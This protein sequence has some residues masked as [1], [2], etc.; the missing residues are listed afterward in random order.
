M[1]GV[2]HRLERYWYI[3]TSEGAVVE[4]TEEM[5]ES[6]DEER[7]Q[8]GNYFETKEEAE[9][10]VEK[11]KAW[12]R[13]QDAGVTFHAKVIDYKWYLMPKINDKSVT[14]KE[15]HEIYKDIDLVFGVKDNEGNQ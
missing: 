7:K 15:A 2:P 13:L 10:A 8:I 6:T 11:L 3:D 1:P 12:K 4:D 9:Q 14:F 5:F